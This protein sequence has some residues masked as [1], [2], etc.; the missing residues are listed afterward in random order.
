MSRRV[1]TS[2]DCTMLSHYVTQLAWYTFSL[3]RTPESKVC[4][5]PWK[6]RISSFHFLRLFTT[7]FSLPIPKG[8]TVANVSVW[9]TDHIH[10]F[11]PS[12]P[13]PPIFM[14]QRF[15]KLGWKWK[16]IPILLHS[17][18]LSF[19]TL[20][21]GVVVTFF[22]SGKHLGAQRQ[23]EGS[24]LKGNK[25]PWFH[26]TKHIRLPLSIQILILIGHKLIKHLLQGI[27][28]WRSKSPKSL[29][30]GN[31]GEGRAGRLYQ[32]PGSS[33]TGIPVRFPGRQPQLEKAASLSGIPRMGGEGTTKKK[34]QSTAIAKKN[35]W[36]GRLWRTCS[37][38]K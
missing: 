3:T 32:H 30:E 33:H 9:K 23:S 31:P 13:T 21:C 15:A 6:S 24:L 16:T 12:L 26:P 28:G 1:Y 37:T 27:I 18:N 29:Q 38:G 20:G 35:S 2:P 5:C 25:A 7:L 19:T 4:I 17:L 36:S 22:S 34:I 10:I 8:Q 11:P 14:A